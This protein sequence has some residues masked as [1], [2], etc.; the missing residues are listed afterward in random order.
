MCRESFSWDD[1][2]AGQRDPDTSRATADKVR[3]SLPDCVVNRPMA[4]SV[5][6]RKVVSSGGQD[7][8][9]IKVRPGMLTAWQTRGQQSRRARVPGPSSLQAYFLSTFAVATFEYADSRLARRGPWS[10]PVV[11]ASAPSGAISTCEASRGACPRFALFVDAGQTQRIE[12]N[13]LGFDHVLFAPGPLLGVG[14]LGTGADDLAIGHTADQIVCLLRRSAWL[15]AHKR[16]GHCERYH[17]QRQ[18][19]A[20]LGLIRVEIIGAV[21]GCER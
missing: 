17:N 5:V 20:M 18:N 8:P 4:R 7:A 19:P 2:C 6:P 15:R 1:A 14:P 16:G 11:W 3:N 13:R 9:E 12:L 21:L 10:M